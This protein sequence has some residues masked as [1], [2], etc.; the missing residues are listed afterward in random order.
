MLKIT[1]D[2]TLD[3]YKELS[4]CFMDWQKAFDHAKWEKLMQVLKETGID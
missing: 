4:A 3:I 1:S 2:Q